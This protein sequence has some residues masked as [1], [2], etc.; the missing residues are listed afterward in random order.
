[1]FE[2]DQQ[3]KIFMEMVGEFSNSCKYQDEDTKEEE[4]SQEGD[5]ETPEFSSKLANHN[6]LHIK[7]KFTPKVLV[8]LETLLG[9]NDMDL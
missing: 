4:E 3:T 6:L 1:M 7:N 2:D 5:K 9:K 8:P